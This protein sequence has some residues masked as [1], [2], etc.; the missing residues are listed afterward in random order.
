MQLEDLGPDTVGSDPE[1]SHVPPPLGMSVEDDPERRGFVEL[2]VTDVDTPTGFVGS[3]WRV[4][5]TPGDARRSTLRTTE[6][7]LDD[8]EARGRERL[9]R[10]K[11]DALQSAGF[12]RDAADED[13]R[14]A[15]G[16]EPA[17]V[18]KLPGRVI[19]FGARPGPLGDHSSI[20]R[21]DRGWRATV[22]EPRIEVQD[23]VRMGRIAPTT[24]ERSDRQP[25]H[26]EPA[27]PGHVRPRANRSASHGR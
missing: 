20:R 18:V 8:V 16:R 27:R 2:A 25:D 14:A 15:F 3:A 17:C 19:L 5:G 26:P 21:E 23:A 10:V 13:A 1:R 9:G 24:G 7:Q 11:G 4:L 6:D 12:G 22:L